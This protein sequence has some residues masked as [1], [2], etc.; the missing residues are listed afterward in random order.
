MKDF[1][2][3]Y[4]EVINDLTASYNAASAKGYEPLTDEQK[5]SMSDTEVEK[6]EDKIKASLLRR[7]GTLD[8]VINT[9]TNAMSKSYKVGDKTMSWSTFG[10]HTLGFLNSAENEQNA[11]HIDG[12]EDDTLTSG[13]AD[14]LMAALT[15]D[16]DSVIDFMQQSVSGLY[17]GIDQ[18]MKSTS[19]RSA[20]TVYN[21]KEMASEYSDYSDVIKQ[22]TTRLTEMEDKYYKQFANMEKQL[23]ALQSNSSSLTGMMG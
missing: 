4:N 16:P 11:Y 9:M 5:A 3:Q 21:D 2:T 7:D 10:V 8:G 12:D 23:A 6:W 18:K 1:L 19:M 17:K 14:K 22:W 13:N 15:R 20:Y